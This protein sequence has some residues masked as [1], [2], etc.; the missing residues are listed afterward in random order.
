ML[1][2]LPLVRLMRW[3]VGVILL[4]ETIYSV[5]LT[6]RW[7]PVAPLTTIRSLRSV[8]EPVTVAEEARTLLAAL[9]DFGH[10]LRG[11][12]GTADLGGAAID[13]EGA[14]EGQLLQAGLGL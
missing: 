4:A 8:P 14:V 12:H 2:I 6:R 11:L 9:L 5:V 1:T 7:P 10:E 3:I 13:L